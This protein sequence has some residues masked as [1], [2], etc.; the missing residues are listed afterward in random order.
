MRLRLLLPVAGLVAAAALAPTAASATPVLDGR[1]VAPRVVSQA[2]TRWMP[3]QRLRVTSGIAISPALVTAPTAA[4]ATA[5]HATSFSF[6]ATAADGSPVRWNPCTPVHWVF[7]PAHAPSGGLAAVQSALQRVTAATGLAF[8][9]DGTSTAVPTG[10]YLDGQSPTA[11]L[12]LLVGWST[13]T[14]STLLANQPS[15]L[16]GMDRSMWFRDASG[17]T[18][19][20]SGVVAFNSLIR[21]GTTGENSWYTYALHELGHAVGL[22]HTSDSTQIMAPVIPAAAGDYGS[23]DLSGLR[24]VGGTC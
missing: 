15:S 1:Q 6:M 3:W 24:R 18:Y 11:P 22:G 21:A 5:A 13:A 4:N 8:A 23:G 17:A 12:P 16:V 10:G 7:N 9:Y 14:E 20:T 19:I 2:G